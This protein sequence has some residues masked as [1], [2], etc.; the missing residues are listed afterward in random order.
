MDGDAT[1]MLEA[2][3]ED[4]LAQLAKRGRAG[5]AVVGVDGGNTYW[6]KR[7]SGEDSGAMVLNELLPAV[8]QLKTQNGRAIHLSKDGNDHAVM[9]MSSGGIAA[10][11]LAWQR[12]DQF[13]RVY[14]AIGTF[15]PMRGGNEYAPLVRKT[16]SKPRA[17]TAAN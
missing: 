12:P 13:R 16:E 6:H 8:E 7:A 5:F 1:Q 17:S 4:G 15:V 10:F 3:V 9:G 14:S 2:G 11:G